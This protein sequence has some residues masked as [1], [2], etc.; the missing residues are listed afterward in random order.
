MTNMSP[1]DQNER[2]RRLRYNRRDQSPIPLTRME[3]AERRHHKIERWWQHLYIWGPLVADLVLQLLFSGIWAAAIL[4]F[5]AR[6]AALTMSVLILIPAKAVFSTGYRTWLVVN[7]MTSVVAG[8]GA[9]GLTYY[10]A[11]SA[12]APISE[13]W[14]GVAGGFVLA[15]WPWVYDALRSNHHT[16]YERMVWAARSKRPKRIIE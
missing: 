11:T 9:A 6:F 2:E 15:I 7:Q 10:G 1:A 13:V 16:D 8:V 4:V 5:W 3:K 12:G 14:L